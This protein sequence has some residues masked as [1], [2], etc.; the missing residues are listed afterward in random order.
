MFRCA[1]LSPPLNSIMETIKEHIIAA[2][3]EQELK[4]DLITDEMISVT[5]DTEAGI[6]HTA[7]IINEE[8]SYFWIRAQSPARIPDAK[9]EKLY[10]VLNNIN[11]RLLFG[12]IFMDE[13][14]DIVLTHACNVDNGA[15][16]NTIILAPWAALLRSIEE[17]HEEIMGAV[18]SV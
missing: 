18:Y 12:T 2:L 3:D 14:G 5:M 7:F 17:M 9:R 8:N 15:I 11:S 1:N 10:P 6:A 13:D 4:Y 16:N